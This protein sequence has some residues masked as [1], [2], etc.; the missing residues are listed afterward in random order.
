[1]LKS[2]REKFFKL[3]QEDDLKG[4]IDAVVDE[5]LEGSSTFYALRTM[6]FDIFQD[7]EPLIHQV[8]SVEMFIALLSARTYFFSKDKS[9]KTLVHA[10]KKRYKSLLKERYAERLNTNLDTKKI[11]TL[12]DRI[13]KLE[14]AIRFFKLTSYFEMKQLSACYD[15]EKVE[16]DYPKEGKRIPEKLLNNKMIFKNLVLCVL[17]RKV[18]SRIKRKRY[19]SWLL[20]QAGYNYEVIQKN[21]DLIEQSSD[22][23]EKFLLDKENELEIMYRS[24]CKKDETFLPLS[25]FGTEQ[26]AFTRIRDLIRDHD[27]WDY[28]YDEKTDILRDYDEIYEQ[29]HLVFLKMKHPLRL[30]DLILHDKKGYESAVLHYLLMKKH[31]VSYLK[32][33]YNLSIEPDED[34]DYFKKKE[35][36]TKIL[37]Q[38]DYNKLVEAE[39]LPKEFDFIFY[40]PERMSMQEVQKELF[41]GGMFPFLTDEKNPQ[42]AIDKNRENLTYQRMIRFFKAEGYDG[43]V[44]RNEKEDK[45]R[46]SYIIF[47]SKQVIVASTA[48]EK[49][50]YQKIVNPHE[51]QLKAWEQSHL[52]ACHEKRLT[53]DEAHQLINYDFYKT[54]FLE[55][56]Q[57]LPQL[58]SQNKMNK[59]FLQ[60]ANKENSR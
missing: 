42:K 57:D 27:V 31:G 22:L 50:L 48:S 23:K 7:G 28:H 20:L 60:L 58:I 32:K 37:S 18:V 19:I 5:A 46:D 3:V 9:G 49:D 33:L 47:H 53:H 39:T 55:K 56:H 29:M 11:A 36:E 25:H 34:L 12:S 24:T 45:G 2:K 13:K 52:M 14:Y 44:Y 15:D 54:Y 51:E 35:Y 40:E 43:F 16:F 8:N 26:A 21:N 1:M 30:P 6:D 59:E 10:M 38:M 4:L 41:L 17:N